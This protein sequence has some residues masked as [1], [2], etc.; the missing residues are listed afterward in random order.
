MEEKKKKKGNLGNKMMINLH[1]SVF[2]HNDD[3]ESVLFGLK[4]LSTLTR[5][6]TPFIERFLDN[7]GKSV[8][9][10]SQL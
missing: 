5:V 4:A 3:S 2:K 9:I 10:N 6:Q 7:S 1:L 8:H